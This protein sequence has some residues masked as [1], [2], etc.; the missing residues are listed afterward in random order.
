[1]SSLF[2]VR[3]SKEKSELGNQLMPVLI[4]SGSTLQCLKK[5][6]Y[7][8]IELENSRG[9]ENAPRRINRG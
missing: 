9:T 6:S 5:Q 1:M 7:K 8:N 4:C 3:Y 2:S